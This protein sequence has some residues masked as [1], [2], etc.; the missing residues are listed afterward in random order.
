MRRD[1]EGAARGEH[2]HTDA[3]GHGQTE[4]P[5][6]PGLFSRRGIT[7]PLEYR[8]VHAPRGSSSCFARGVTR[9]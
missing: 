4:E 7:E 3:R 1:S 5:K 2:T 9:L 6:N 8:L